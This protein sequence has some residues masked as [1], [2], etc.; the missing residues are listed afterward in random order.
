M[1]NR[2]AVAS[3]VPGLPIKRGLLPCLPV[4]QVRSAPA[5]PEAS[6]ARRGL[7]RLMTIPIENIQALMAVERSWPAVL[8]MPGDRR[9][10]RSLTQRHQKLRRARPQRSPRIG[11]P[12]SVSTRKQQLDRPRAPCGW[13]HFGLQQLE[14]PSCRRAGSECGGRSGRRGA[15]LKGQ[16]PRAWPRSSPQ[17]KSRITYPAR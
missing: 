1:K 5:L 16:E 7:L 17:A 2:R 6:I 12:T 14:L 15:S 3:A 4:R 8:T 13:Q 9:Q 10:R 11:P